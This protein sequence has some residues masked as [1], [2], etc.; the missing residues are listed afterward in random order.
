LRRD[1]IDHEN[2]LDRSELIQQPA[3]VVDASVGDE[4][5]DDALVL[6][7]ALEIPGIPTVAAGTGTLCLE[8]G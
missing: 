1:V 8:R 6:G 2:G 7:R 4:C 5:V 3:R